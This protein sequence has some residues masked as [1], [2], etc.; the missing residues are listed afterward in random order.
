MVR[1]PKIIAEYNQFMLGVD[2]VDQMMSYYCF[3]RKS[4]KWWRK[5]FF[6]V[7]DLS[8]VN[9]FII[10]RHTLAETNCKQAIHLDFRR[11]IVSELIKPFMLSRPAQAISIARNGLQR[12]NGQAHFMKKMK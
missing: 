6:W 1:K 10:F 12:M 3:V 7:L 8:I 2:K 5:V 11:E 9:S 4:I